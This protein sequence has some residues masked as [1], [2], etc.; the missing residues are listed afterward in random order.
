MQNTLQY[1]LFWHCFHPCR[2]E[3]VC[4][5]WDYRL[6]KT[7]RCKL[8]C[9]GPVSATLAAK[10]NCK[11]ICNTACV[12]YSVHPRR[13]EH[14]CN[15]GNC[16]LGKSGRCKVFCNGPLSVTLAAEPSCKVLCNTT[17]F[18]HVSIHTLRT[19]L[20]LLELSSWKNHPLQSDL[21]QTCFIHTC[22]QAQLQNALQYNQ[23]CLLCRSMSLR[24]CLQRRELS[25]WKNQPLQSDLQRTCFGHTC[26]QA[27]LQNGLQY[28]LFFLLDPSMSLRTCL[29]RRKL[30]TWNNKSLQSDLQRTCFG[31]TYSQAQLQTALQYELGCLLYPSMSLR[32]CLQ[33][34]AL[35]I[36]KHHPLQNIL[37]Q[38]RCSITA[39]I[40]SATKIEVG[41]K[42]TANSCTSPRPKANKRHAATTFNSPNCLQPTHN[43]D[44]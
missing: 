2:G 14:V 44:S 15:D 11:M 9:N 35:S 36:R 31:H 10:P 3:R 1:G 29:Q 42:P 21:Q 20:Q 5:Y 25:T 37:Q 41:S 17:C 12:A 23:F 7:D 16:R 38:R 28:D 30:T 39:N 24:M 22:S 19:C 33:V 6:G 18:G 8:I 34:L 4:N 13:C 26:R 43:A 27:Q 32:T 40:R